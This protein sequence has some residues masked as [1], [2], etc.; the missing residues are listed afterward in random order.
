MILMATALPKRI[1]SPEQKEAPPT[2]SVIFDPTGLG[3]VRTLP[4]DRE[5][6]SRTGFSQRPNSASTGKESWAYRDICSSVVRLML[7]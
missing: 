1:M 6:I 2:N 3:K 7:R 4:G 5:R